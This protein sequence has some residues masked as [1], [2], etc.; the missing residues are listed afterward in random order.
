MI[1]P[2]SVWVRRKGMRSGEGQGRD[3]GV[4]QG[5]IKSRKKVELQSSRGG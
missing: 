1:S 5:G 4:N 2:R 3:E